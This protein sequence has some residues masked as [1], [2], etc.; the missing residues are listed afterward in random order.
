MRPATWRRGPALSIPAVGE[1]GVAGGVAGSLYNAAWSGEEEMRVAEAARY[2][3]ILLDVLLP[4]YNGFA[5]CSELRRRAV[6]TPILHG[7]RPER[8]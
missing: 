3:L 6:K 4:G 8:I 5:V 2:D 7:S 1:N